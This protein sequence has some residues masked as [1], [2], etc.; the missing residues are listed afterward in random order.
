VD[1]RAPTKPLRHSSGTP[2]EKH[3][4]IGD[5]LGAWIVG[6]RLGGGGFGEVYEA[7]HHVTKQRAA[8]KILH[9]HFTAAPEMVAR[10]DREIHVLTRLRHPNIVQITDAGFDDAGRPYLCMEH[11]RGRDLGTL[12]RMQH[13]LDPKA[14]SDILEPLCDAIATAHDLGVI[15]RDLKA[16]N[17]FVCDDDGRVVLLDFGI[18]KLSDALAPE[19]TA[20]HESLGTPG[21]MAPEQIHGHT[22]DARTDVYALGG[23]LF[24]LLTGRLPFHDPSETMTQYLHLHARRPRVSALARVS[25]A[26]DDIVVRA[27]AIE[28]AH[29][30]ADVRAFSAAA[31]NALR[32]SPQPNAPLEHVAIYVAIRDASRGE[33]LDESLLADLEAVLPAV[34]RTLTARGFSLALDLGNSA[35]FIAPLLDANVAMSCAV[36]TWDVLAQRKGLDP[37]VRVGLAVHQGLATVVGDR[38]EPCAL[39]RPETWGMPEPLEGVWT[40]NA[41]D[42]QRRRLR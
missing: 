25:S 36:E 35:V 41:V 14:V 17:V 23:L 28:P 30:F 7:V 2:V 4:E 13:H 10:F 3:P 11:L 33:E 16:S 8:L 37:R 21:C 32:G 6:A 29:R 12:L 38:V 34:E 39:L 1:E 18:A 5:R 31:R 42:P 40:T 19:L 26:I 24:H 20:S 15:H 22:I 9:A 27:M